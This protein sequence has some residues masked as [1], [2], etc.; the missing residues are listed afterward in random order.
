MEREE[1]TIR[2]WTGPLL[3]EKGVDLTRR[4][5]RWLI[6]KRAAGIW[7]LKDSPCSGGYDKLR[8]ESIRCIFFDLFQKSGTSIREIRRGI[9]AKG[10]SELCRSPIR[11]KN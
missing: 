11:L 10:V 7:V 3:Y 9:G 4:V 6:T 1:T 5:A 2:R 8:V